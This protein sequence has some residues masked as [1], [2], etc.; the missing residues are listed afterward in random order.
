MLTAKQE[1][2]R[3]EGLLNGETLEGL[4][5]NDPGLSYKWVIQRIAD[6]RKIGGQRPLDPV[7]D[8]IDRIIQRRLTAK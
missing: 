2:K 3:L 6:L 1:I 5:L 7:R 4:K 8:F